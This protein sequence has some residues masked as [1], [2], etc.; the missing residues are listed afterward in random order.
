M[1][2]FLLVLCVQGLKKTQASKLGRESS[3]GS[4]Q[5]K[6]SAMDLASSFPLFMLSLVSI[7][8]CGHTL[9][10]SSSHSCAL[11]LL[12]AKLELIFFFLLFA[13]LWQW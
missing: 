7:V 11:L 9:L 10:P 1:N 2:F 4:L 6:S 8:A 3:R 12:M 13:N 5:K